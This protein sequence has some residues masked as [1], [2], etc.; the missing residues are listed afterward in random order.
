MSSHWNWDKNAKSDLPAYPKKPE[1]KLNEKHPTW[2]RD[3]NGYH[4]A[5]HPTLGYMVCQ[6]APHKYMNLIKDD[7]GDKMTMR[8]KTIEDATMFA[9]ELPKPSSNLFSHSRRRGS[10]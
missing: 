9:E 7:Q 8:L 2:V 5:L 10:R 3:V 4:I 6:K 1:V